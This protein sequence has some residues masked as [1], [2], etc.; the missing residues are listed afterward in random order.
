MHRKIKLVLPVVVAAI[1]LVGTQLDVYEPYVRNLTYEVIPDEEG[2]P[3]GG[4]KLTWEP[5]WEG[6]Y[7]GSGCWA[8]Q[9]DLDDWLY[10]IEVDGVGIDTI[11][12]LEY[13]IYTSGAEVRVNSFD[14]RESYSGWSS[15]LDLEPVNLGESWVCELNGPDKGGIF[16]DTSRGWW[17]TY[18]IDTTC[19]DSIDCYFTDFAKG[20]EGTLYLASPSE[21]GNDEGNTW[22]P[23]DGW[24][25]TAIS[26]DLGNGLDI[27]AI[28]PYEGYASLSTDSAAEG[29]T[30]SVRTQEGHYGLIQIKRIDEEDWGEVVIQGLFQPIQGLR[31][32]AVQPVDAS[33][34]LY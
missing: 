34:R 24:R 22:L 10:I 21:L 33:S 30:F 29:A 2:N 28:V 11:H 7:R 25:S 13:Y 19:C 18:R 17:K 9:K 32:M 1:L 16:F 3:G 26:G 31:W 6:P 27:I 5:P 20:F 12:E 4:L 8:R 15:Q 14:G 23:A